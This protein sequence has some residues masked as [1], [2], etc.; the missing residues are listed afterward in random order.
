MGFIGIV[1]RV[2]GKFVSF[3]EKGVLL[4]YVGSVTATTRFQIRVICRKAKAENAGFDLSK[5]LIRF[6][7]NV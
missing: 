4:I 7:G 3:C 2:R 6:K 1:G 5:L